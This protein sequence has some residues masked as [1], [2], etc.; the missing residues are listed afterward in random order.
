MGILIYISTDIIRSKN[1]EQ[2]RS[3][4]VRNPSIL[5][6]IRSK[7]SSSNCTVPPRIISLD[8]ILSNEKSLHH[9]MVYLS[10]E[11]SMECLLSYIEVTQWQQAATEYIKEN[12]AKPSLDNNLRLPS[13][14]PRGSTMDDDDKQIDSV[15]ELKTKA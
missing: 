5:K 15:H 4:I 7:S 8:Q 6:R 10:K 13:L 14:I 3:V 2:N 11:L 12:D 1:S 9:F